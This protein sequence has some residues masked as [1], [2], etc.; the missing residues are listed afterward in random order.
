MSFKAWIRSYETTV[1]VLSFCLR[2]DFLQLLLG[3]NSG[4]FGYSVFFQKE[5]Y[6]INLLKFCVPDEIWRTTCDF[7]KICTDDRYLNLPFA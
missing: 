3:R 2:H 6:L 4:V 5:R 7:L 1:S